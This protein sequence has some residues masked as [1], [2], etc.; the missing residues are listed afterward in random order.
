MPSADERIQ[1]IQSRV[2]AERAHL[3][4]LDAQIKDQYLRR[5]LE[6]ATH[7]LDDVEN[8]FLRSARQQERTPDAFTRWL[9]YA[10]QPLAWAIARRKELE[11]IVAKYGPNAQTIG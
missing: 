4:A 6:E 1:Q 8:V 7:W 11:E 10:E 9:S 5:N 3:S 2:E